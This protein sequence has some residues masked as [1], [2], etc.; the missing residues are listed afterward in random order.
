MRRRLA[1]YALGCP[2]D[3]ECR[4]MEAWTLLAANYASLQGPRGGAA[5]RLTVGRCPDSAAFFMAREGH[6]AW[7]ADDPGALLFRF[8]H[9][10]TVALQRRRR[11]L[12]FVHAAVLE[13][14]GQAVMLVGASGCG[15]STTAWALLQH[16]CRYFS[17]ELG[18]V[19][20]TTLTVYPYPRALGLKAVPPGPYPL[21]AQTLATGRS[22]H[23]PT[24]ALPS[25]VGTGPAPLTAMFFVHYGPGA[26]EPHL[27][28]LR[29]AEAAAHLLAQALNPLAHP[30]DGLDGAIALT[31]ST[32][33]FALLTADLPATC[34][35]ILTALRG[36][37]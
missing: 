11:D 21:P 6:V 18:P 16:G 10:L 26:A 29:P 37:G 7:V 23:I 14:A 27:R 9:E 20:P 19:D 1:L 17:D 24:T 30:A 5:L 3:V 2:V 36:R 8:E 12:Y 28:P 32:A 34:D 33:C 25:G 22:F 4:D 35:V 13:V 31:T 15:K